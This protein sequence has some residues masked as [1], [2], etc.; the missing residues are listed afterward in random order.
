MINVADNRHVRFIGILDH[1]TGIQNNIPSIMVTGS[2][3]P[4]DRN[5]IKFNH[6]KGEILK[7]DEL[8]IKSQQVSINEEDFQHGGEFSNQQ[9]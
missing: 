2:H 4:D 8:G 9:N 1:P 3:I 6:P 7:A 5:G